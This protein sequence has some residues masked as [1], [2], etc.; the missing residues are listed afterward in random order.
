MEPAD[1]SWQWTVVQFDYAF[2]AFSAL[3]FAHR[4]FVAATMAFLPAAES[5]RLGLAAFGEGVAAPLILAH[6]AF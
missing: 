1:D 6:L 5:F 3:I 2:A 4:F